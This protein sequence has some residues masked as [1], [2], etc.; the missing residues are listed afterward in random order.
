MFFHS[1]YCEIAVDFE[2]GPTQP[3]P[4]DLVVTRE[5][6]KILEQA[7]VDTGARITILAESG[8]MYCLHEEGRPVVRRRLEE[9][10]LHISLFHPQGP[11]GFKSFWSAVDQCSSPDLL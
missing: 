3:K 11:D 9:N 1:L 7:A 10:E 5:R 4:T 8:Q 2:I 6:Y